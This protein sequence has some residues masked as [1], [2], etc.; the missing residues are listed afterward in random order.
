LLFRGRNGFRTVSQDLETI[1]NEEQLS[2][3]KVET[4]NFKEYDSQIDNSEV[5]EE[6]MSRSRK[7]SR[8]LKKKWQKIKIYSVKSR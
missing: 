4:C 7:N 2:E 6:I 1:K 5:N 3:N 8:F